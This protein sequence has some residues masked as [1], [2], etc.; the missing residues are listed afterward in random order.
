ML[1]V[2]LSSCVVSTYDLQSGKC[3][4]LRDV[5]VWQMLM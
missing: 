3:Q 5:R 2:R 4:G 1:L